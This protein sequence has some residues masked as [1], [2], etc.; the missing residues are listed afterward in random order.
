[1]FQE[2]PSESSYLGV[3][4][5]FQKCFFAVK[6]VVFMADLVVK[7]KVADAIRSKGMNM[8]GDTIDAMDKV[9]AGIITKAVERCKENGRKTVRPCD[10]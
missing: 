4:E 1:V 3:P 7:S 8:A 2:K 10:L 9:V 5:D 6:E